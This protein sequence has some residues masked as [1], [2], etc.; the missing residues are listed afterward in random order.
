MLAEELP[1]LRYP[2]HWLM[3]D[4][5]VHRALFFLFKDQ[6]TEAAASPTASE[7]C[8]CT[9]KRAAP[10]DIECGHSGIPA[11]TKANAGGFSLLSHVNLCCSA[12]HAITI[13]SVIQSLP[14]GVTSRRVDSLVDVKVGGHVL[15]SSSQRSNIM[16]CCDTRPRQC[17][18]AFLIVSQCFV[19]RHRALELCHLKG[20]LDHSTMC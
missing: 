16:S 1:M 6:T 2:S 20:E 15:T 9:S 7:I 11:A 10:C 5:D 12:E 8:L 19:S 4:K 3:V 14:K 18:S 17:A 13:N